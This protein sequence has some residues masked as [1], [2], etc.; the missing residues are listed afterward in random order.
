M[1]GNDR[2][3]RDI[4][5]MA[6]HEHSHRLPSF[7][8]RLS[9]GEATHSASAYAFASLRLVTGFV[10]LWAFLDKTFGF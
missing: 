3:R 4:T 6:V 9:V 8:A 10:F 1:S 7:R 2:I 5:A